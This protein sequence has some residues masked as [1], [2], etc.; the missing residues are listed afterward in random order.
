MQY[1]KLSAEELEQVVGWFL[2]RVKGEQRT[3][4]MADLPTLYSKLFPSVDPAIIAAAVERKLRQLQEV[5]ASELA[6]KADQSVSRAA[7][8]PAEGD[9]R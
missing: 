8:A 2:Y 1:G 5:N 6:A 7:P 3:Q 9:E 4:L